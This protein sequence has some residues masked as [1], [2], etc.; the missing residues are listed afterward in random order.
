[1]AETR[2]TLLVGGNPAG[3]LNM[4]TATAISS[5]ITNINTEKNRDAWDPN[6]LRSFIAVKPDENKVIEA[7]N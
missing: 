1:M 3:Q 6:G 7:E 4:P 2:T 5:Y